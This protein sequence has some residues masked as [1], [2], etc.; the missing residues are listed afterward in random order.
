MLRTTPENNTPP[1]RERNAPPDQGPLGSPS[2]IIRP[3]ACCALVP[4]YG[5]GSSDSARCERR[6]DARQSAW[7]R[8]VHD[9]VAESE[10]PR[11]VE[12]LR[13]E[14]RHVRVSA[15]EGHLEAEVLDA[16]PDEV[17]PCAPRVSCGNG[18]LGYR[19]RLW[20]CALELHL[21]AE[22]PAHRLSHLNVW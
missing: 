5:T 7:G 1:W 8:A 18:V 9:D 22:V 12:R 21:R 15:N 17:V 20:P 4:A 13:E 2:H 10:E 14:I 16:F 19:P 3:R 6:T 11:G